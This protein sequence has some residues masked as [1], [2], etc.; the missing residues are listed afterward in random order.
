MIKFEH[1]VFALPFAL[2]GTLLAGRGLPTWWQFGWILS[3]MIGA[4]SAAMAFNRIVDLQFDRL[5]PRTRDRALPSG[6]L[7]L[8]F[9]AGFTLCMSA[10]F[11]IAAAQLNPLCFYLSFPTLAILFVYS[12]TKRFTSLSHLF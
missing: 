2:I 8:T 9:A 7:S 1:T 6:L 3:A 5:N 4:R 12:F 11:I 10:L